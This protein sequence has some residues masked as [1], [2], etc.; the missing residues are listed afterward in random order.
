MQK[1]G[2]AKKVSERQNAAPSPWQKHWQSGR[3]PGANGLS[4]CQAAGGKARPMAERVK[5]RR[6]GKDR[7][8]NQGSGVLGGRRLP[9][10]GGDK[11]QNVG[12]RLAEVAIGR[13]PTQ[14]G[15]GQ[16]ARNDERDADLL[17]YP[18]KEPFK[19]EVAGDS[20]EMGIEIVGLPVPTDKLEVFERQVRSKVQGIDPLP[21]QKII[22][23]QQAQLMVLPLRQEEQDGLIGAFKRTGILDA[24]DQFLPDDMRDKMFLPRIDMI[25]GPED[26]DAIEKGKNDA[27][28][29]FVD[30]VGKDVA[31]QELFETPDVKIDHMRDQV[32]DHTFLLRFFV[33]KGDDLTGQLLLAH[34]VYVGDL[35]AIFAEQGHVQDGLQLPVAV[36]SDIGLRPAGLQETIALLPYSDG[37]GLDPG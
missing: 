9:S 24:D 33:R 4:G 20:R 36:K 35:I 2:L 30:A 28:N 22:N 11:A 26:A 6:G 14:P 31:I 23:I 17:T 10:K 1:R 27:G 19:V 32:I 18:G 7:A 3:G 12:D 5:G 13:G 37:M 21:P 25:G 34:P 8:M 16:L 29:G 15:P